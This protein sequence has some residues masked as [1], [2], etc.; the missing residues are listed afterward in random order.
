M[1]DAEFS[2]DDK[3]MFGVQYALLAISEAGVDSVPSRRSCAAAFHGTIFEGSATDCGRATTASIR[4]S[5][6]KPC[7]GTWPPCSCQRWLRSAALRTPEM[8]CQSNGDSAR[9]LVRLGR[10]REFATW[11]IPC[12]LRPLWLAERP[13]A[14]CWLRTCDLGIGRSRATTQCSSAFGAFRE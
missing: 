12:S 9:K 13:P 10:V 8:R 7:S 2:R 1:D 3:T 11:R 4:R 14:G 5:S 6:G